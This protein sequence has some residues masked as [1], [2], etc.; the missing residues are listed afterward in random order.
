MSDFG[1]GLPRER[2]DELNGWKALRAPKAEDG[3]LPKD[4]LLQL[5]SAK[6]GPDGLIFDKPILDTEPDGSFGG[7]SVPRGVAVSE[8]G[9]VYLADPDTGRVL[10]TRASYPPAFAP[11][12]PVAPFV[13]LWSFPTD[14]GPAHPLNLVTPVDLCLVP[15]TAA[16]GAFGDTLVVA[17][18]GRSLVIWVDR[19]QI[20]TRHSLSL[21]ATPLSLAATPCGRVAVLTEEELL[22]VTRGVISLRVALPRLADESFVAA[23]SVIGLTDG[24][25][26]LVAKTG[27]WTVLPN[28]RLSEAESDAA[29][30]V[31]PPAFVV[32]RDLL[33]LPGHCPNMDSQSYPDIALDRAGRLDGTDLR[34]V[35][36]PRRLPVP[37]TGQ[38]IS[39]R[40]DGEAKGFAWDRIAIEGVVPSQCRLLVQ[41]LVSDIPYEESEIE[42][43]TGWSAPTVLDPGTPTEFLVQRN[44][45][46]YL[47]IKIEAYGDGTA[48]PAISGI[49]L[50]GPRNS[51]MS[52]LPAPF[53]QDPV[54]ADFL[55]RFLSLQD[56]FLGEALALFTSVGPMLDPDATPEMFLDWFGSWFDWRFLADWDSQTR[57]EMIA[58]AMTFFAERG[59][60]C[61]LERLLRWH[62]GLDGAL[63]CLI[64]EF[65]LAYD[66][67]ETA[68]LGNRLSPMEN[69]GAH[70]FV[71][72]VPQ[73]A[74]PDQAAEDVLMSLI[75]AQKPAHTIARLVVVEPGV[76]IGHQA[77]LGV[78]AILP[79]SGPEALG[80]GRLSEGLQT[81]AIC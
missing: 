74:V 71:V 25:F 37:R 31:T 44:K 68:W 48:T 66:G 81:E 65:R 3:L 16:P 30:E 49:D 55:D 47:W 34:L 42:T 36:R 26:V 13:P 72:V 43:F 79:G 50:Y 27:V 15:V 20:V 2:L 11:A 17:D 10:Y 9:D 53:H 38:W 29:F 76:R 54:S 56:A 12:S 60:I 45:G 63:P 41:T 23:H 46:R 59:T 77:R 22:I 5:A 73:S 33:T 69:G 75:E 28:G 21:S 18:T 52:L 62:T 35:S 24:R 64:E 70:R 57:R 67:G 6:P 14:P 40:F 7:R 61:G 1:R 32:E 78:D 19:R 4:S 39:M 58:E 51:Q 80:L 8:V